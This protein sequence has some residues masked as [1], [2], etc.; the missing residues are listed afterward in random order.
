MKDVCKEVNGL[1]KRLDVLCLYEDVRNHAVTDFNGL[2]SNVYCVSNSYVY[3][4]VRL[5]VNRR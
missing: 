4:G 3:R 1:E 2:D 5:V